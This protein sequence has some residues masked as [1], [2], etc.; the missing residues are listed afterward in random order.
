MSNIFEILDK[1]GREI[2][3]TKE[4]WTHITEPISPHSYMSNYLED[5]K[6]TIIS[7]DNIISSIYDNKK[8]NYYKYFKNIQSKSKFLRVIVKYLNNHGFVISAYLVK[9]VKWKEE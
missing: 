2:S 9:N 8:A 3:L 7:P 5:I 6:Q 4:R 1:K